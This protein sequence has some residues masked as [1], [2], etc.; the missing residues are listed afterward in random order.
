MGALPAT[1]EGLDT[2]P[3]PCNPW[4]TLTSTRMRILWILP[5]APLVGYLVVDWGRRAFSD[6]PRLIRKL[7]TEQ[8]VTM[9]TGLVIIGAAVTW[10]LV[11]LVSRVVLR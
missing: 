4:G 3:V 7:V 5:V 10:A 8:P 1:R 6:D 9:G 2:P 11:Q